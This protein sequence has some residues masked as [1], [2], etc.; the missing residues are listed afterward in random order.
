MNIPERVLLQ[1]LQGSMTQSTTEFLLSQ[2]RR[3]FYIELRMEINVENQI[4]MNYHVYVVCPHPTHAPHMESPHKD[5][6]L[7]RIKM[8][9]PD[10]ILMSGSRCTA[11]VVAQWRAINHDGAWKADRY[12]TVTPS[13]GFNWSDRGK[14]TVTACLVR[15]RPHHARPAD[16]PTDRRARNPRPAL[17]R[18]KKCPYFRELGEIGD[19]LVAIVLG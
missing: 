14:N 17:P 16:R 1:V 10:S 13:R 15:R 2:G 18:S 8:S 4:L 3:I 9:V 7:I 11:L 12:R 19:W 5:Q 6:P